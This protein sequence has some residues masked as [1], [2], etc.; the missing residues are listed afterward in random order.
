[1]AAKADEIVS[2]VKRQLPPGYQM[3]ASAMYSHPFA[4]VVIAA[5]G[6]PCLYDQAAKTW[7]AYKPDPRVIVVIGAGINPPTHSWLQQNSGTGQQFEMV[8]LYDE[9]YDARKFRYPPGW[10]KGTPDV[11]HNGGF[12]LANFVDAVVYPHICELVKQGRGPALMV[13]GSRGGQV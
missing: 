2:P 6:K 3:F 1:M 7:C 13:S 4:S 8:W 9:K 12:N 11:S 10:K 5:A